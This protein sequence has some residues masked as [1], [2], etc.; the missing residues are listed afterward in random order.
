[1]NM[2]ELVMVLIE[3]EAYCGASPCMGHIMKGVMPESYLV[4][5][6]LATHI[7]LQ[8]HNVKVEAVGLF[9]MKQMHSCRAQ[10]PRRPNIFQQGGIPTTKILFKA[11]YSLGTSLFPPVWLHAI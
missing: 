11:S 9:A 10:K 5:F 1:M 6:D 2:Y 3:Q 4:I 7:N 8:T